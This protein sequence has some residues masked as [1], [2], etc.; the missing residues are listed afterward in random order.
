MHVVN[1][2]RLESLQLIQIKKANRSISFMKNHL[3]PLIKKG[4]SLTLRQNLL[5]NNLM[6]FRTTLQKRNKNATFKRSARLS[7]N[8][9]VKLSLMTEKLFRKSRMTLSV[10]LEIDWLINS[11]AMPFVKL[12]KCAKWK[13]TLLCLKQKSHSLQVTSTRKLSKESN[14]SRKYEI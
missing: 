13:E 14:K 8:V 12:W 5:K 3:Q 11:N 6:T 7:E 10:I 1:K 4:L 2:A 9:L